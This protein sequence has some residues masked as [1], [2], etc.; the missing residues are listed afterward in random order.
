MIRKTLIFIICIF[1]T[2]I[3]NNVFSKSKTKQ[4]EYILTNNEE[5]DNVS[6]MV[7]FKL[8][9]CLYDI[10][11]LKLNLLNDEITVTYAEVS[12]HLE[13]FVANN[14]RDSILLRPSVETVTLTIIYDRAIP[15]SPVIE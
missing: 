2:N 5:L 7:R 15:D 1:T 11:N 12:P 10:R 6:D 3:N 14:I 4:Y 13:Y 9:H 8:K